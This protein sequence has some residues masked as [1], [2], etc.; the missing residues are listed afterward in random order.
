M[1]ATTGIATFVGQQSG[2]RYSKHLYITDTTATLVRWDVGSGASTTSPEYFTAPENLVLID[3][4]ILAAPTVTTCSVIV[5]GQPSGDRLQYA[6]QTAATVNRVPL[7][8]P[9]AAGA[10]F[11]L[12]SNT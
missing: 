8:I 11:Q 3:M 9:I 6:V 1:A 10:Q 2:R 4:S 5:N 12:S 7:A